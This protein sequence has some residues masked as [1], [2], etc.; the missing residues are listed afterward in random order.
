M[1]N[2][3]KQKYR[4]APDTATILGMLQDYKFTPQQIQNIEKNSAID[5]D[6]QQQPQVQQQGTQ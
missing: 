2:T 4:S 1:M 3:W 6:G 5:L